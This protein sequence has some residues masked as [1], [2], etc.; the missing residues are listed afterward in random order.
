MEHSAL[1][2]ELRAEK[3]TFQESES[4]AND[5]QSPLSNAKETFDAQ[6]NASLFDL[7]RNAAKRRLERLSLQKINKKTLK[8]SIK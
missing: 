1:R 6:F 7:L 5:V 4:A 2:L 3:A 8:H